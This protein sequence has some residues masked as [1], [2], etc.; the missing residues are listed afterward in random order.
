MSACGVLC[1]D[2][3]AYLG[4]TKGLAYQQQ[5]AEAWHR[6]YGLNEVASNISC[7]GCLGPFEEVF[8][9]SRQCKAR[10]CCLAKG[11][12]NCAECPDLSCEILEKAQS[13]WDEV[14]EQISRISASD[15]ETYARPYCGHR[16]RL[17]AARTAFRA[18][19][20]G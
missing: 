17:A 6:I 15:F 18:R 8:H 5:V 4:E 9:T 13:V 2:C 11:F 20:P 1:T 7:S 10:D 14:P 16:Q 12:S 19:G 3:P